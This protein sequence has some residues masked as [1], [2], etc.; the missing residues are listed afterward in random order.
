MTNPNGFQRRFRSAF[1]G[2]GS[3]YNA[4][5]EI[6]EFVG[7]SFVRIASRNQCSF[8]IGSYF[9][10]V[11]VLRGKEDAGVFEPGAECGVKRKIGVEGVSP[12]NFDDDVRIVVF[13]KTANIVIV[14]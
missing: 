4:I 12:V 6:V 8:S 7:K 5:S 2:L 9:Y 13:P 1:L 14:A 3:V 11:R 10:V